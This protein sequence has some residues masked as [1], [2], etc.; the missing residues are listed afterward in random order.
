M[1]NGKP[2]K[3]QKAMGLSPYLIRLSVGLEDVE[4][5]ISDLEQALSQVNS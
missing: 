2:N 4:D 5:L 1:E 3:I